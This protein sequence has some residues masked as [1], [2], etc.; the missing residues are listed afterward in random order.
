MRYAL[1]LTISAILLNSANVNATETR[2]T[3]Q[4][5]CQ[6]DNN[7]CLLREQAFYEENNRGPATD[8]ELKYVYQIHSDSML[9]NDTEVGL[10]VTRL[11]PK[12]FSPQKIEPWSDYEIYDP[13]IP[14]RF[15][16]SAPL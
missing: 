8:S 13:S 2:Y 5:F 1:I 3:Y 15:T 7:Q 4:S 12:S 10:P 16:T 9:F 14:V 6:D 11:L